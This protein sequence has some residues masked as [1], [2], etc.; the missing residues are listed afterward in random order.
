MHFGWLSE[1]GFIDFKMNYFFQK[2]IANQI[3]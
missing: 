2:Y 3:L 1:Y